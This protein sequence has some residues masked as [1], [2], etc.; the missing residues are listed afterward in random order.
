MEES[1]KNSS[2]PLI[3]AI[4]VIVILVAGA[5]YLLT[6]K[7]APKVTPAPEAAPAVSAPDEELS[8]IEASLSDTALESLDAD[9]SDLEQEVVAE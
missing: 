6:V 8:N 5:I 1:N 3:G 7:T 9:L 4:I 2:G